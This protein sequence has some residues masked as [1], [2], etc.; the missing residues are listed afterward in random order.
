M[1]PD[2]RQA[3]A[4]VEATRGGGGKVA[5]TAFLVTDRHLLTAFHVVGDRIAARETGQAILYTDLAISFVDGKVSSLIGRV[6]KGC[7]DPVSDWALIELDAPVNVRP[8][9]LGTVSDGEIEQLKQKGVN[10]RWIG[11]PYR[12]PKGTP[13]SGEFWR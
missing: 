10:R 13:L 5:G 9:S 6:V 3:I 12:H 7:F 4:R 2:I 1:E 8:I 11:T